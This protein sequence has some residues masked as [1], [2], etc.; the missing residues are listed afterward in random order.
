MSHQRFPQFKAL[1]GRRVGLAL[2]DGSRIDDCQLISAGRPGL[3][4][5]WVFLNGDDTFIPLTL[6]IEMWEAGPVPTHPVRAA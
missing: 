1:E 3:D 4:S 6:V 2:S 5:V